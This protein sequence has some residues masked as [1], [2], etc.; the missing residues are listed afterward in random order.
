MEILS[1]LLPVI[2]YALLAIL[3]VVVIVFMLRLITIL[4]NANILVKNIEKKVNKF[5]GAFEAVDK[6]C[7]ALSFASDKFSTFVTKSIKKLV[8]RKEEDNNE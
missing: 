1:E 2:I 3:I 4:D 5:N 7:D 6:A 8:E